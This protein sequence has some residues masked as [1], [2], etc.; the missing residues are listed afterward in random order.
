MR[1]GEE[2]T[3]GD[4]M[5]DVQWLLFLS[6]AVGFLVGL[7]LL[8]Q[9]SVAGAQY[10]LAAAVILALAAMPFFW[11]RFFTLLL[12]T[13]GLAV[14]LAMRGNPFSALFIA[15]GAYYAY[16]MIKCAKLKDRKEP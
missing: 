15:A 13:A 7:L 12:W 4:I 9:S 1:I 5:G 11:I 14:D 16:R 8:T 3:L 2:F 10:L 6:S